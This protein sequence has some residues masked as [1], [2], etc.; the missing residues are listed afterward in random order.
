M[1]ITNGYATLAELKSRLGLSD[2]ADDAVLESVVTAVSRQID[3]W[4]GRRFWASTQTRL[5]TA[6]SATMVLTDDVLAVTALRTDSDGDGVYESTWSTAD[7][8]LRPA[9]AALESQAEPYTWIGAAPRAS[10]SFPASLDEGVQVTGTFGYST[11]TPP[12]VNEA[13]LIQAG[14]I[15]RR[16]DAVFG[17][18]GSA[19]MGQAI[20]VPRLDPDVR[21]LL[22]PL[23]RRT[24]A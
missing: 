19:E 16:R 14:R 4:C 22:S 6:V 18:A 21:A 9:N 10:Y 24:I 20:V 11:S 15:F 12:V 5:Y 8:R 3:Q 17:I 2:T 23:A 13:C 7:Y 1:A